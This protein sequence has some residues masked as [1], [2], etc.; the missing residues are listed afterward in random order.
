MGHD[1]SN[2]AKKTARRGVVVL[3]DADHDKNHNH[4]HNDGD[5]KEK[6][7]AK[8]KVAVILKGGPGTTV[9]AVRTFLSSF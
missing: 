5:G 4:N 7:K 8:V 1:G 9:E 6:E 2:P 3:V